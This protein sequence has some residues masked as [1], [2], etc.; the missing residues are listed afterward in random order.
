MHPGVEQ[1]PA[2]ALKRREVDVALGTSTPRRRHG[3]V[4]PIGSEG[5]V[6][7]AGRTLAPA[8]RLRALDAV[9]E[10]LVDRPWV[11]YSHELPI[12]RRFWQQAFGR[13]FAADLRLAAPELRAVATAVAAGMGTSLLPTFV[14]ADLLAAG[15]VVELADVSGVVAHPDPRNSMGAPPKRVDSLRALSMSL[16]KL[17]Q[18]VDGA[19]ADP[20]A[21]AQAS[22]ALLSKTL[23]AT[24]GEWKQLQQGDLAALDASL[25]KAGQKPVAAH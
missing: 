10:W 18:A 9:G 7:V 11:A 1:E 17:E 19:D 3:S 24:L 2:Q 21:D 20:S 25:T 15:T 4:T 8:R 22:W 23:D 12:T 6:L 14:V 5:F 13:P 16:M